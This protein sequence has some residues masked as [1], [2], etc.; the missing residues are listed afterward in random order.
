MS[1][2]KIV[3]KNYHASSIK[4][5]FIP[6][7]NICCS[8]E[9]SIQGL[10]KINNWYCIDCDVED[11]ITDWKAVLKNLWQKVFCNY[12]YY[13]KCYVLIVVNYYIHYHFSHIDIK[14]LNKV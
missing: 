1:D 10:S 9:I 8:L 2:C 4:L 12:N 11:V 13:T 6:Y 14:S 7:K 3:F 5:I